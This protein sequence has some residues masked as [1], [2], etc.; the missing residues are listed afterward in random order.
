MQVHTF[1]HAPARQIMVRASPD[2]PYHAVAPF[3]ETPRPW[4]GAQQG[5]VQQLPVVEASPA[6]PVHFDRAS[7]MWVAEQGEE[8]RA[9]GGSQEPQGMSPRTAHASAEAKNNPGE[10]R[11]MA[12]LRLAAPELRAE[13]EEALRPYL[14]D[15]CLSNFLL[16]SF[17]APNCA[18]R[19]Q[20]PT[21]AQS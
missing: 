15:T 1:G 13:Y 11:F 12:C 3:S 17:E 8:D 14:L 20:C 5:G 19:M 9:S 21:A 18:F 6:K 10:P 4:L 2:E 7:G 16:S